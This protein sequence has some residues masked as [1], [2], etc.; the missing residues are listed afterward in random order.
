MDIKILGDKIA[1]ARKENR[2]SQAQLAQLLFISPQAVRKWERCESLP[3]FITINRLAEIFSLEL[4]YFSEDSRAQ[5]KEYAMKDT[6]NVNNEKVQEK[7]NPSADNIEPLLT[8]FN[9][10][11]LVAAD[12][13]GVSAPTRKF[14]G[15]DLKQ[16]DF[17]D[18]DLT[19]SSFK[20]NDMRA[21][22]FEAADLTDCIISGNNLSDTNFNKTILFRTA[23][24]A[25]EFSGARF[26]DVRL[27]NVKIASSDLRK[28]IFENCEFESVDFRSSDMSG[29]CLDGQSS[30]M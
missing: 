1:L 5:K 6:T 21:A 14:I 9:G 16:S 8:N 23:F 22:N 29:L 30:R 7:N 18:A 24:S 10:V 19:G 11:V 26:T 25:S 3:D 2:M 15:S 20:N 12:F 4:A 27:A 17:S 13:A 28:A